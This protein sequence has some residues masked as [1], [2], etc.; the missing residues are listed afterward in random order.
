MSRRA[1]PEKLAA[2]TT[3]AKTI[4]AVLRSIGR[5]SFPPGKHY[6]HES[7]LVNEGSD[8]VSPS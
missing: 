5:P 8:P 3:W 7:P 1:A 4:I 2:S 6:F